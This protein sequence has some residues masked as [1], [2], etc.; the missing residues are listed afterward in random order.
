MK[1]CRQY[2]RDAIDALYAYWNNEGRNGLIVIPTGGGKSLILATICKELIEAFPDIRIGIVTHVKEL[3]GQNIAELFSVWNQAPAGIYS[4]GLNRRDRQSQILFMSIQ[5]VYKKVSMLG[6][7]DLLLVDECHLIPRSSQTMYG[8]FISEC[9]TT[10]PDMRVAGFT[11]TPFRLDSGSLVKGDDAIF[12]DIV[13]DANVLDL[14]NQGYLSPLISKATLTQI[15][16]AGIGKQAGEFNEA[17]LDERARIPTVVEAAVKE[18]VEY[19]Q[20]R[21]GWLIF[22]VSIDHAEQVR[23]E[24]RRHNV[25]CECVHSRI[26]DS[27]RASF[28]NGFKARRIRA[29]T[30]VG[31]LTTGFNAPHVDLLAHLRPTLSASLYVQ[32]TGRAFRPVYADG[33]DL[34]T[35]EGRHAAIAAGPKPNALILDFSGNVARH[36]PLDAIK[37]KRGQKVGSSK[38]EDVEPSY[39]VC[40][41]CRSY[42]Q[43]RLR[44]CPECNYVYPHDPAKH[45]ARADED[46]PILSNEK[47]QSK[48]KQITKTIYTRHAKTGGGTDSMRAEYFYGFTCASEWVCFEHTGYAKNKAVM[49]WKQRGGKMPA[50]KTVAE[51]IARAPHELRIVTGVLIHMN[52]KYPQVVSVEM[53]DYPEDRDSYVYEPPNAS[54]EAERGKKIDHVRALRL[55]TVANG[56]T[57]SEAES[58]LAMARKIQREYRITDEQVGRSYYT[59]D[60][61]IPF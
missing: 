11:A 35:E 33:Y 39:K 57:P 13:Y 10:V 27:D 1:Q 16:T 25:S 3:V 40:P 43:S 5:S 14:I 8:R 21:Q 36:G 31:V 61:D 28:I 58:A 54:Y 2:Q 19:G 32:M 29:L 38:Q 49:W 4:A 7:F 47:T 42:I 6:G 50:P 22:C 37:P 56:C 20:N 59:M 41:Q 9:K 23:D 12:N 60:E 45:E 52:G 15:D 44:E 17:Q 46:A 53:G 55:K 34:S 18:I 48:F 24:I 51:G 30:S 26:S